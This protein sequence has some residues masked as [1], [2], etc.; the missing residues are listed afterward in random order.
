[1]KVG[2]RLDAI[3]DKLEE[4]NVLEKSVFAAHVGMADEHLE[5]DLRKLRGT[6]DKTGY[7][8]IILVD[9]SRDGMK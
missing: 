5:T 4:H 8:S 7:L 3:L 2:K 9:T 6:G 1:M